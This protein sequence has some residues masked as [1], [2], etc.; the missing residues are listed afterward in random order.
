[1]EYPQVIRLVVQ[2]RDSVLSLAKVAD[3]SCFQI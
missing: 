1:M 3:G 2:S